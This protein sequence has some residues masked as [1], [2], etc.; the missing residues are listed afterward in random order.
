MFQS[1]LA[2][3]MEDLFF[4]EREKKLAEA[5]KKLELMQETK[6]NLSQVSG[7]TDEA[8]LHRLVELDIRPDI[9]TSLL[10]IP[11]I[12]V[13]WS[14]G[15][16]HEKEREFFLNSVQQDGMHMRQVD[17]EILQAWLNTKPSSALFEAWELYIQALS[18]QLSHEERQTLKEDVLADARKIA[19]AAGGFLGFGKISDA[20][21]AML[22]KLEAAFAIACDD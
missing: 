2:R 18:A 9:L 21:Q 1:L 11:L 13:A 16:I 14:D 10:V 3:N 4:L 15:E 22:D 8:V 6:E 20:E 12:E 5:R 19:E 17:P 7:I